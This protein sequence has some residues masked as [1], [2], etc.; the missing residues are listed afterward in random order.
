M[1]PVLA[2]TVAALAVLLVLLVLSLVAIRAV[3][4]RRIRQ[5]AEFRPA[6]ETALAQYLAGTGP[7]PDL[8]SRGERAIFLAIAAEALADLRGAERDR[9]VALLFRLGF[10]QDAMR[11]LKARRTATRRSAAETLAIL[12]TPLAAPAVTDG[13]HDRDLLVRTTC[14]CTLAETGSPDVLPSALAVAARDAAAAPG[15]AACVVLAVTRRR[16][17]ALAPLLRA[18]APAAIRRIAVTVAADLR[19]AELSGLLLACLDGP[20][21]LA[22]PAAYGLGRIGEFGASGALARLAA[23][24]H[25]ALQARSAAIEAL[26]ALGDP[27]R[28]DLLEQ[29]LAAPEWQLRSAAAQSLAELGGPGISALR[30]AVAAGQPLTAP[31]AEAALDT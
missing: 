19:L 22:A 27:A 30:R 26:G 28:R 1:L 24:G 31:L 8:A 15:R 4:L 12:A 6:A 18:G 5:Q 29:L 21:E 3:A 9:L 23:D 16:P 2:D 14:A 25:R 13:L 10:T 7:A 20:A 11:G 17:D